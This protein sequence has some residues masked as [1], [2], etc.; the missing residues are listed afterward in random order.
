MSDALT[1]I[2]SLPCAGFDNDGEETVN[3][4]AAAAIVQELER[5]IE[6]LKNELRE[7]KKNR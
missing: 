3:R 5:R 7:A 1:K 6:A 4:E 2:M